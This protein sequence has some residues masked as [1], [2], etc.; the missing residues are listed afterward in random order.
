M[1]K[2]LVIVESPTKAKT[3]SKFLGPAYMVESSFGHVRDLPKS[4]M[5][6]DIEGGTFDPHYIVSRDK[7]KQVKKLKELAEKADE[8]IFA[9]DEDREG[10][11]ISW[12]LAHILKIDPKKAQRIAFHEI[13]KH[14]IQEALKSP[15][16]I[17]QPLVDAQQARRVLDRLVGYELSPL[18]WRK[19][20]KG[21]SAGRVQSVAV[22]LIVER[23]K[24]IL[25]FIPE[26]YWT[27]SGT[28]LTDTKE[29]I[30][31]KL[32]AIDGKSLDKFAIANKEEAHTI[33]EKLNK[34]DFIISDVVKKETKRVPPAPFTTSTL[35]QRSNTFLGYS[36]RQTM[37]LA[38]QLYEGIN[39]GIAGQQGLITYMR[40]DST[41][42]SEKFIDEANNFITKTFGKEYLL[43]TPRVFKTKTKGAQE[44]H[45][46]IRPT[47]PKITPE[48]IEA[49][50]DPQ[51]YKLYSLIW[52][53]TMASQM[54]DARLN[55][56]TIDVIAKEHTFRATGQSM[57]FPGWM[58]L[59]PERVKEEILPELSIGTALTRQE[60]NSEQHFTEPPA[61]YSDAS[62][63]KILE[64][65]GIGRPSTYAP[66]IA[67]IE[68]RNYVERIDRRLK[69]TPIAI[70]VSDLLVKHFT[71]I[72]DFEFTAKVE[73]NL[74]AIAEGTKDW[75]PIISTF[76][77]PFHENLEKKKEEITKEQTTHTRELGVDP[78]TN[79]PI[80]VKIG[81]YGPYIQKG[82]GAEDVKPQFA[83]L[84]DGQ[85]LE[86]VTLEEALVLLSLP[87]KITMD[88]GI[89][90]EINKGRFGPYVKT[91]GKYYSIPD[92]DPYTMTLEEAL[93]VIAEGKEKEDKKT[94]HDFG[95]SGIKVLIGRYGEYITNGEK[96]ARIPKDTDPKD[97]T[98]AQCAELLE[99][100]KPKRGGKKKAQ[101]KKAPK[102]KTTK[103][104]TVKKKVVKEE[105]S[106]ELKE[107]E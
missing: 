74:D 64:E 58:T 15:R 57:I 87:R 32:H 105:T 27:I 36:S 103:K 61:R 42:L 49:Y 77:H 24:E 86:T 80:I 89:V 19:V 1:G 54:I 92:K 70:I 73:E 96:N 99:K 11:A 85:A 6:I 7:T 33:L 43:E 37:R 29:A 88:D 94:I 100:A 35:Q 51:Q 106:E 39:I 2:T 25:A 50:L 21:L 9:T 62:L 91:E 12:H 47:D 40:T 31:T 68:A 18:L 10:E 23:E 55:K 79:E 63:V 72:V 104:K 45:E 101:K 95:D 28:F 83:S 81:R 4:K 26:E 69:P 53:R 82:D 75:K 66:T 16:H 48:S 84:E 14:A 90:V 52:R 8:I 44:A 34:A 102:K 98:E 41:N 59:Y 65:H 56:T 97:L 22:R 5:G 67:T 30:Q 107:K 3:I 76:Y 20:A 17:N 93:V 13:T 38:Q 71:N 60:I 46:A 78:N